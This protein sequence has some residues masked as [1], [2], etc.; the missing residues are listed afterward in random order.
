M[1]LPHAKLLCLFLIFAISHC[2]FDVYRGNYG[3]IVLRVI[4]YGV[5]AIIAI[6]ALSKSAKKE[7]RESDKTTAARSTQPK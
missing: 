2:L 3:A 5:L 4:A 7:V 6:F 1:K